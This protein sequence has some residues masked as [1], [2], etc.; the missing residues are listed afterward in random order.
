MPDR[1]A[2][3]TAR[4][5]HEPEVP[6]SIPGPATYF[7]FSFRLF[8]KGS[9]HLLKKYLHEVLVNRLGGLSLS[10]KS[11]GRLTD[12]PDMTIDVNRGRKTV[13]Q[14]IPGCEEC[15]RASTSADF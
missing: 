7:R 14:K 9:C 13:T 3:S 2:Q 10:R 4:L 6:G 12:R 11:V 1:V 8:K 15:A 5:T